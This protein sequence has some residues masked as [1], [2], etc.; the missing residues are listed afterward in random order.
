MP[1]VENPGGECRVVPDSYWMQPFVAYSSPKLPCAT[2]LLL[3]PSIATEAVICAVCQH[4][5]MLQ[6]QGMLLTACRKCAVSG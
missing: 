3:Q 2:V 1:T 5:N 4:K 6:L